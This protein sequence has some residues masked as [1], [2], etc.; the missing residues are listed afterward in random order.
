MRADVNYKAPLALNVPIHVYLKDTHVGT[1][2]RT[3]HGFAYYPKGSR[4]S[5][6]V[7]PTVAQIKATLEEM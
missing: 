3:P 5:G 2:K 4:T 6:E 7:L 1:I